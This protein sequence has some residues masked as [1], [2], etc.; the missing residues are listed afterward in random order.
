[1]THPFIEKKW[2]KVK[3]TG[4][5]KEEYLWFDFVEAHQE[6]KIQDTAGH[7]THIAGIL[8]Q[9][10][11]FAELHVARVFDTGQMNILA[12]ERVAKVTINLSTSYLSTTFANI[13][14]GH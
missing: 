1:L 5:A 8:L 2:K 13:A 11:P 3:R 10:A 12:P 9:L 6:P 7:G 14:I 4:M